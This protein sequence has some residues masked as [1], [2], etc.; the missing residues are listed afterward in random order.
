MS[1]KSESGPNVV[2]K[3]ALA[4]LGLVAVQLSVSLVYKFSIAQHGNYNFSPS[5]SLVVSEFNKMTL[6]LLFQAHL[7]SREYGS[8]SDGFK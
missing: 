5:S 2:V 8:W 4:L 1:A 3:K 7:L 6:A